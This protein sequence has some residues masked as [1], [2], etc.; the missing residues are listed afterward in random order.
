MDS[1]HAVPAPYVIIH[2]NAALRSDVSLA[3]PVVGH[4]RSGDVVRVVAVVSSLQDRRLR[5]RIESPQG[6]ISLLDL[7]TGYRWAKR[8]DEPASARHS[9]KAQ[10]ADAIRQRDALIRALRVRIDELRV[11][12]RAVYASFR[13][14]AEQIEA[15]L[16]SARMIPADDHELRP[17]GPPAPLPDLM[18]FQATSSASG[19]IP[20]SA[21]DSDIEEPPLPPGGRTVAV[22]ILEG[23]DAEAYLGHRG[24]P[25]GSSSALPLPV[26]H[27]Y[28]PL[29]P[30]A[31]HAQAWA[32]QQGYLPSVHPVD[33][34]RAD[35]IRANGLTLKQVRGPATR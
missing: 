3:S 28:M 2:D 13:E 33:F 35:F 20:S 19:D 16:L 8:Y 30:S 4:L 34:T 9:E 31:V 18:A 15:K 12:N 22:R 23:P 7:D 27:S 17:P 25:C 32:A 10:L 5:G 29:L 6:W 11:N 14:R 1:G 26:V 24:A 21:E